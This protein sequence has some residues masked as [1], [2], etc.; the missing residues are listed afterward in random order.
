MEWGGEQSCFANPLR[1]ERE[2]PQQRRQRLEPKRRKEKKKKDDVN[3][4]FLL[5]ER[6]RKKGEITISRED[7]GQFFQ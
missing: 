2:K 3:L 7:R 5:G 1:K 6:E 4:S